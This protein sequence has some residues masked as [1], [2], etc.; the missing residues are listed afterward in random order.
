MNNKDKQIIGKIGRMGL[1]AINQGW[2]P[3]SEKDPRQYLRPGDVL[4][5]NALSSELKGRL[6]KEKE[7]EESKKLKR[8]EVLQKG[9]KVPVVFKNVSNIFVDNGHLIVEVKKRKETLNDVCCLS[10]INY[11]REIHG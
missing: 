8:V 2:I 1:R 11:W 4:R 6:D 3:N 7:I 10:D 9:K 5:Y